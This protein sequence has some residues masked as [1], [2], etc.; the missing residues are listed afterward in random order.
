MEGCLRCNAFL[1]LGNKCWD[2]YYERQHLGIKHPCKFP[3][4]ESD[5]DSDREARSD[6]L[7]GVTN[8]TAV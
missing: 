3:R 5:M 1:H 6:L 2:T 4:L 7:L 8:I